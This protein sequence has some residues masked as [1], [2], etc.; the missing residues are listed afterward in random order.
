MR[1]IT[2]QFL[3]WECWESVRYTPRRYVL[4]SPEDRV[5]LDIH[6][7]PRETALRRFEAFRSRPCLP[8]II[9]SLPPL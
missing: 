2:S 5:R 9:R 7:T 8:P 6:E 3:S 4:L 1:I